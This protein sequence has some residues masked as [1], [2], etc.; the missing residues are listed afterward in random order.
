MAN[1]WQKCSWETWTTEKMLSQWY[2]QPNATCWHKRWSS[3]I[4]WH[5]Q[6][7]WYSTAG[8]V[9]QAMTVLQ[10]MHR[11]WMGPR[12]V[13]TASDPECANPAADQ[14]SQGASSYCVTFMVSAKQPKSTRTKLAEG[15]VCHAGI[16]IA[17]LLVHIE[18]QWW[19]WD[20][21]CTIWINEFTLP[22]TEYESNQP[23]HV[24]WMWRKAGIAVPIRASECPGGDS[25]DAGLRNTEL[26]RWLPRS[27]L[28]C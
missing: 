18:T 17:L 14:Y 24:F 27:S 19:H 9:L 3:A 4:T 21:H 22:N 23:N 10:V 16:F 7:H 11:D 1:I 13:W 20:H 28:L 2:L 12:R 8:H 15:L 6:S 5:G 26:A 25:H